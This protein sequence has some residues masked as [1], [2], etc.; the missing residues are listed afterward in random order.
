MKRVV[1]LF[2]V[3]IPLTLIAN[4]YEQFLQAQE[5]Y[6]KNEYEKAQITY[7]SLDGKRPSVWHNAGSCAYKQ[8]NYVTALMYWRRAQ[9]NAM[10]Q[11]Y[12]QLEQLCSQALAQLGIGQTRSRWSELKIFINSYVNAISTTILQILF[13][14]LW[15][16]FLAVLF[17][18]SIVRT[19]IGIFLLF[20]CLWS[21]GGALLIQYKL[22]QKQAIIVHQASVFNGPQ[23]AYHVLGTLDMA[24]QVTVLMTIAGWH[25][26]KTGALVGWIKADDSIIL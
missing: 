23:A 15:C 20:L 10:P 4:D 11:H 18:R 22:K 2:L 25:K 7:E 24:T 17:Y 6:K 12:R 13:L 5:W 16:L 3:I 1:A 21:I 26:I 8:G 19:K 9:Q 14:V